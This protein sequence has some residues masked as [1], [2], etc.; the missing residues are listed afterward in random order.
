MFEPPCHLQGLQGLQGVGLQPENLADR[1]L[2][3]HSQPASKIETNSDKNFENL[4]ESWFRKALTSRSV[5]QW[6]LAKKGIKSV[7]GSWAKRWNGLKRLMNKSLYFLRSSHTSECLQWKR[8][9]FSSCTSAQSH[10]SQ[11]FEPPCHLQDSTFKQWGSKSKPAHIPHDSFVQIPKWI[12]WN[13]KRSACCLIQ[14]HPT[15]MMV[16][17][18]FL[19]HRPRI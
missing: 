7:F 11:M 10:L 13:T 15:P 16:S 2:V 8:A 4:H 12:R 17:H 1:L 14:G 3:K 6:N 5:R 18:C 19:V 9:C